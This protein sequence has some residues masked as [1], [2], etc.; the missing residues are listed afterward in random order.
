MQGKAN[1]RNVYKLENTTWCLKHVIIYYSL[2]WDLQA[3]SMAPKRGCCWGKKKILKDNIES[4]DETAAECES[5]SL[6]WD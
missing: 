2:R 3:T 5:D 1:Q 4:D 6:S